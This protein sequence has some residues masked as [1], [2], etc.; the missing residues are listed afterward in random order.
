MTDP[1]DRKHDTVNPE[2]FIAEAKRRWQATADLARTEYRQALSESPIAISR[3]AV[4][5]ARILRGPGFTVEAGVV[6]REAFN[7]CVNRGLTRNPE[8]LE[9]LGDLARERGHRPEAISFY[10]RAALEGDDAAVESLVDL[11]LEMPLAMA[12]AATLARIQQMSIQQRQVLALTVIA[13]LPDSKPDYAY[14]GKIV[15]MT[16][17]EVREHEGSALEGL[18]PLRLLPPAAEQSLPND[19]AETPGPIYINS[20]DR[21]FAE[22]SHLPDEVIG[23][24]L[25]DDERAMIELMDP[26]DRARYLLQRRIQEKAE[27]ATLLSQIQSLRHQTAMSIINNIR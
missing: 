5:L 23:A 14:V 10:E 2:P 24:G 19:T 1:T 15:R 9:A 27:T 26:K 21:K 4:R 22:P 13:T 16:P 20:P 8:V 3:T 6:L 12:G 17:E 11:S 18:D 25:T 7:L